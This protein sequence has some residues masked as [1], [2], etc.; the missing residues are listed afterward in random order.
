M[1]RMLPATLL[2][3]LVGGTAFADDVE[4]SKIPVW[5][6]RV[7]P[8]ARVEGSG[9]LIAAYSEDGTAILTAGGAEAR[10]WDA[11]TFKPLTEPLKH[12]TPLRSA[13]IS[14]DG[15]KVVTAGGNIA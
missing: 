12:E 4:P 1:P 10:V 6:K 9:G 8:I 15:R 2:L 13:A 7:N 11:R 14:A 5:P 3:L